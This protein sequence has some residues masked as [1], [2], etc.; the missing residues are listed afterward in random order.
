MLIDRLSRNCCEPG[1]NLRCLVILAL[2]AFFT[3]MAFALFTNVDDHVSSYGNQRE[4]FCAA[5]RRVEVVHRVDE[6]ECCLSFGK[7]TSLALENYKFQQAGYNE[8]LYTSKVLTQDSLYVDVGAFDGGAAD[9]FYRRYWPRMILIEP[10]PLRFA[11][12]RLKYNMDP[13]VTLVNAAVG[14]KD[15]ESY[16]VENGSGSHVT[17]SHEQN[18]VPIHVKTWPSIVG[19]E[20]NIDLLYINCEGCEY[21]VLDALINSTM[22]HRVDTIFVQFHKQYHDDAP[23]RRCHARDMLRRTHDLKFQVVWVWE[24][25]ERRK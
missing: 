17:S 22:I 11:S 6:N 13:K 18:V 24:I 12:L 20:R 5:L 19:N 4:T 8:L 3:A 23:A 15:E 9:E 7:I 16:L 10:S 14:P 2:V 1:A 21:V 25:W